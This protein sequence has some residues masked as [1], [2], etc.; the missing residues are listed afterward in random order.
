MK[1]HSG[2]LRSAGVSFALG[3]SACSVDDRPLTYEYHELGAAGVAGTAGR[4][5]AGDSSGSEAGA[6]AA[7][8]TPN[9]HSAAGN[10]ASTGGAGGYGGT[11]PAGD[12]GDA[13]Q[14]GASSGGAFAGNGSSSAGNSSAG[15]SSAGSPGSGGALEFPCGDLN[16][17][18]VDD[19]GQTLVKNSRFDSEA[20]GW[21]AEADLTQT[22]DPSNASGKPGPGSLLLRNTAATTEA[23]GAF[24]VGSHQC[25]VAT[26]GA[27]Y[28]VAARFMLAAD[29]T[30]GEAGVNIWLFDD[31]A[32]QGN[33]VSGKTAISGGKT[34]QWLALRGTIWIP[35]GVHSMYV[36]LVAIKPFNQSS[37]S[38]LVDDVLIAKR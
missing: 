25:I 33:L 29:Q 11:Q 7:T 34:G 5:D 13:A 32:C 15:S 10:T 14:A 22:W 23:K 18:A 31:D 2:L 28:D 6:G 8:D 24:M 21:D 26:P 1:K 35:G 30:A 4:D 27:T 16:Q 19:C 36:R 38:V 9:V 20:S 12:A 17:D 37:L 3:F